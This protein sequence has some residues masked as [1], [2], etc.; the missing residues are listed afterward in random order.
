MGNKRLFDE[1]LEGKQEGLD[2]KMAPLIEEEAKANFA[3][4]LREG[5]KS[6]IVMEKRIIESLYKDPTCSDIDSIADTKIRL[7]A[8]SEK[9]E[10]G[11]I[12][13][14]ELFDEEFTA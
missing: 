11:K 10:V 4:F 7:K 6:Q 12:L 14:K 1:I 13:Y 3:S 9:L 2:A 8:I 5:K